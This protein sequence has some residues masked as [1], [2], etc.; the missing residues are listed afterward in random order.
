MGTMV[1]GKSEAGL[2]RVGDSL[3]VMPNRARVKVEAIFRDE[4]E[5]FAAKAGENL[6]LRVSGG[7]S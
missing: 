5:S 4:K 1:M 7:C 3:L 2:L 6:R